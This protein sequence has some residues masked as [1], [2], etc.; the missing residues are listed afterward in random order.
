MTDTYR[1]AVNPYTAKAAEAR[2]KLERERAAAAEV[3]RQRA[4]ML[5]EVNEAITPLYA[6]LH[7]GVRLSH[8]AVSY[9]LHLCSE[10]DMLTR[11]PDIIGSTHFAEHAERIERDASRLARRESLGLGT[12][13]RPSL[14]ARLAWPVSATATGAAISC[15]VAGDLDPW[16]IVTFIVVGL[17]INFWW[18][19]TFKRSPP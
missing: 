8:H 12:V 15:A 9:G 1:T 16:R 18:F 7:D 3:K 5:R 11:L 6:Y 17:P 13:D 10:A 19:G 2:A 14:L 4:D